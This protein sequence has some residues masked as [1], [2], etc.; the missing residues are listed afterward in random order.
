MC[1]TDRKRQKSVLQVSR[2]H[3]YDICLSCKS[4][5]R[6]RSFL[7]CLKRERSFLISL[8]RDLQDRQMS[9]Y[10]EICKAERERERSVV[11]VCS[12]DLQDR[13]LSLSRLAR[14]I[15]VSFYLSYTCVLET[16]KTDRCRAPHQKL[17]GDGFLTPVPSCV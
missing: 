15:S 17:L 1:T 9:V 5:Q 12:R 2:A 14:Q 13:S 7:I 11:H 3:L 16:C 10:R 4:L 8:S 6:Q